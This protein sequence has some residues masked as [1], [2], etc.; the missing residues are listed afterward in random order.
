MTNK[1]WSEKEINIIINNYHKGIECVSRLLP[2][3]TFLSIKKKA[4]RLNL[5]VKFYDI[6]LVSKACISS[7]SI[8]GVCRLLNK[9]KS[10]DSYKVIKKFI[11]DNNISISHFNPWKHNGKNLNNKSKSISEWLTTESIITS[12]NLKKKLYKESL[13]ERIC[14]MC[15]QTEVWKGNKISLILDHINGVSNDNRIENLRILCP[16]CN[17]TL[18]TH[19]RGHKGIKLVD[20]RV[21]NDNGL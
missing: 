17:A 9:S 8:A 3:R 15:G 11:K 14:E 12:S 5:K 20:G 2:N 19:C 16:N 1:K 4:E 18:E 10:G 13:K 6:E 7:N 21:V